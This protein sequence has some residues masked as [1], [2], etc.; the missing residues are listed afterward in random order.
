MKIV[1]STDNKYI[2][3]DIPADTQRGDTVSLPDFECFIEFK[4][5]LDNGY[6]FFGNT[7]FQFQCE[8]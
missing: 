8:E 6:I 7:N 2:G 5:M 4:R 1:S 3:T